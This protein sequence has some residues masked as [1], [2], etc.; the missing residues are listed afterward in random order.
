[1]VFIMNTGLKK[2]PHNPG[3]SFYVAQGSGRS[4]KQTCESMDKNVGFQVDS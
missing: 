2:S 4:V 3:L 1:M